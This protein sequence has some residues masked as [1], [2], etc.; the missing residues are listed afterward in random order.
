MFVS[1]S[2]GNVFLVSPPG[3]FDFAMSA[4]IVLRGRGSFL[5][6][7]ETFQG[8]PTESRRSHSR[9]SRFSQG[10]KNALWRCLAPKL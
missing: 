9:H 2:C 5:V 3:L 10:A 4:D 1:V 8:T 6:L 7:W